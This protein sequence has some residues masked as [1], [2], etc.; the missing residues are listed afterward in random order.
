MELK[1]FVGIAQGG[2]LRMGSK[3]LHCLTGVVAARPVQCVHEEGVVQAGLLCTE[4]CV[5]S[6]QQWYC[7]AEAGRHLLLRLRFLVLLLCRRGDQPRKDYEER[8]GGVQMNA[9]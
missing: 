2:R 1:P 3:P 5:R 8:T 7:K 9:V 4:R 6:D